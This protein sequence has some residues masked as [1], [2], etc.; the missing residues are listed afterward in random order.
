MGGH[1]ESAWWE[2]TVEQELLQ[3]WMQKDSRMEHLRQA[4]D[5][6]RTKADVKDRRTKNGYCQS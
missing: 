4:K 3:R 6:W 2:R 1:L 5:L